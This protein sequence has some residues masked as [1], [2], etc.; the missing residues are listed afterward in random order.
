MV[1]ASDADA[2]SITFSY[3]WQ[4]SVD[5]VT[6]ASLAVIV[7]TLPASA[8]VAGRYY[9][10]IITPNDGI[11]DGA[12]FVTTSIFV[13]A[14][15]DGDGLNDDWELANFGSM[16]S[17]H[18]GPLDD[19]D[20]DGATNAREF[21]A[22]TNPNDA[23]SVFRITTITPAPGGLILEFNSVTGRIYRVEWNDALT[24]NGWMTLTNHVPGAA[25]T[26]QILAP[27]LAQPFRFFRVEVSP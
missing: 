22:G 14:D 18:G 23:A 19:P 24:T 21:V 1:N 17:P 26:T 4:E 25:G 9:R 16:N 13:P 15:S 11:A 12:P 3:Q 8:T 20:G 5:G 2:D 10:A 27:G 6:F 7:A